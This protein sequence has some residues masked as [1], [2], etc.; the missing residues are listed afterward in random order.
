MRWAHDFVSNP[1]ISAGFESLPGASFTVFGA[2]LAHDS[3]LTT[4]GAQL[5]LTPNW[6]LLA[7]FEG[8]FANGSQTYAGTGTFRYTW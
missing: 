2:P 8:E 6:S 1:A 7:K 4:L 5:F 3:A